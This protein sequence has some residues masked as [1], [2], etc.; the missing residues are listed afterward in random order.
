MRIAS[1]NL[2]MQTHTDSSS[3]RI[4]LLNILANLTMLLQILSFEMK[5]VP[6]YDEYGSL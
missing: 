3:C 1:R 2:H 4:R 6:G 5:S